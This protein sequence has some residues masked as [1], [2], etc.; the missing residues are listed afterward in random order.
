M[1]AAKPNYP[2]RTAFHPLQKAAHHLAAFPFLWQEMQEDARGKCGPGVPH[3]EITDG[4]HTRRKGGGA[5][6]SGRA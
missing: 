3:D 6:G 4:G 1:P 2:I 5:P